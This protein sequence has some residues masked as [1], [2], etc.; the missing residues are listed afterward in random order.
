MPSYEW[1]RLPELVERSKL[2]ARSIRR[3]VSRRDI[4]YRRIGVGGRATLEFNWPVV[5][6]ELAALLETRSRTAV[7]AEPANPTIFTLI[8]ELR[9][10][11]SLVEHLIA[12]QNAK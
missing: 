6:R 11:R 5:E 2:N 1:I 10:L 8:T 4:S 3:L 12:A 7:P 9:E